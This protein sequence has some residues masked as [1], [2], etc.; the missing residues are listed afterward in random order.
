M[1]TKRWSD[2]PNNNGDQE[3]ISSKAEATRKERRQKKTHKI[4]LETIGKKMELEAKDEEHARQVRSWFS[5]TPKYP[6]GSPNVPL[7]DFFCGFGLEVCK[8]VKNESLGDVD[9]RAR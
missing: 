1:A 7:A 4:A 9:E 6:K 8:L 5:D 2:E 3:N